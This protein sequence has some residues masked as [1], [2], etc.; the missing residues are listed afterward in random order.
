[1]AACSSADENDAKPGPN[2]PD[3]G[4]IGDGDGGAPDSATA[5]TEIVFPEGTT[6]AKRDC[7]VTLR[8]AGAAKEVKVAG[9]FTDWAAGALTMT[10]SES[11][12]ETKVEPGPKVSPD[13]LVAYKLVVDGQWKLDPLGKYRRIVDGEMNSALLLPSCGAGPELRS[14]AV[15]VAK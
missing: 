13:K 11:G 1:G 4:K 14:D 6:F 7:G 10:K 15:T 9:E 12:F 8:W 2:G 3:S 5:S